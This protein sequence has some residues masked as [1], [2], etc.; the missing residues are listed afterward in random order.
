[1]SLSRAHQALKKWMAE[2]DT[3]QVA[4]AEQL[5]RKLNAAPPVNQ[6]T[7]GGWVRDKSEPRGASMLVALKEIA[8]IE[9]AWWLEPAL[10]D[11]GSQAAA[12]P[13]GTDG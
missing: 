3:S 7:V 1:M 13:T 8:G 4:L 2:T 12:K 9:V 6:T 5:T 10:P 11:S